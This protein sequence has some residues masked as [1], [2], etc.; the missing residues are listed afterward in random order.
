ML[1]TRPPTAKCSAESCGRV[2]GTTNGGPARAV[3]S[4]CTPVDGNVHP[5]WPGRFW[6][7]L[8]IG[9]IVMRR[10][11][12]VRLAYFDRVSRP[13]KSK[14]STYDA[15]R[16]EAPAEAERGPESAELQ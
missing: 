4:D 12:E 2:N 10:R 16:N 1:G 11:L 7:E 15:F 6:G 8:Q 13:P 3:L 5:C 14:K 9:V